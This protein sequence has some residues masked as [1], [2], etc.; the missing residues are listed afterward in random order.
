[1]NE[2][3]LAADLVAQPQRR[4]PHHTTQTLSVRMLEMIIMIILHK[5]KL[6]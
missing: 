3:S 4:A 2:R 1:M 6:E 5:S